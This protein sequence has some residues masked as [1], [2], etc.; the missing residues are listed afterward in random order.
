VDT[1]L[2]N[3]VRIIHITQTVGSAEGDVRVITTVIDSSRMDAHGEV[4]LPARLVRVGESWTDSLTTE[5]SA[6]VES[7]A[8]GQMP[9]RT[10]L[11]ITL[12]P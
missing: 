12:L 9:V 5:V 1:T 3:L 6:Q 4:S 2:P 7:Q 10:R 11:T 8:G